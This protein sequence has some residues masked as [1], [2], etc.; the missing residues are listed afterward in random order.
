VI[1][2][3]ELLNEDGYGWQGLPYTAFRAPHPL[4]I[5][6]RVDKP[7]WQAASPTPRFVDI[8]SGAPAPFGTQARI[9]WDDDNLYIGFEAEEPLV[10][11][12][13]TER[14]SL[15]FFE[16]DLEVFIDGVDSYYELEFNALGTI[17]EVFFVWRD[18]YRAGS[19]WAQ[20]R[21]DVHSPRVH[22]F[23]GDH[24]VNDATFWA[25]AHPRGT[26][27]AF[28]DYDM[29]GLELAVHVDGSLNDPT[30]I[31]RG[32]SAEVR[33]PWASLADLAHGRSLPPTPGDTWSI[34]LGRFEQMPTREAGQTVG[35]GWSASPHGVN[36]T[37]IPAS[38][39]RVTFLDRD[40]EE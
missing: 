30:S 38:W 36:D 32:W 6:G 39:T 35:L 2:G 23:S 7:V 3:D 16:N 31:D 18:A 8:G 4:V 9:L 40:V 29:P 12:R 5:D 10:S 1:N 20:P 17:Y 27:W 22:S 25:G 14:D 19:E 28:L 21:F 13:Y 26:R 33:V 11:A 24:P 34:F 37:H 15:I